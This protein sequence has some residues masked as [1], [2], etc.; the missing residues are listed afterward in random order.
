MKHDLIKKIFYEWQDY[1]NEYLNDFIY[2][3]E[4]LKNKGYQYNIF[5]IGKN[6]LAIYKV[7]INNIYYLITD[8]G[9]TLDIQYEN[10]SGKYINIYQYLI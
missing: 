4:F 3:N 2:F 7:K 8:F 10:K 1:N 5:A 9:T 6:N